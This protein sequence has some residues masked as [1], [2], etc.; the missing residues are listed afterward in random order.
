LYGSASKLTDTGSQLLHQNIAKL[1]EVAEAGDNF[2]A[3]LAVGDFNNDNFTDL[4]IGVPDEDIE[5]VVDAGLVHMVYGSASGLLATG[6][7][8]F[9]RNKP[10]LPG[11]AEAD[12]RFG[13]AFP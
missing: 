12:D 1:L 9:H 8:L 11:P 2:G 3:T 10:G 7:Q 5:D 6:N 4:A 13:G